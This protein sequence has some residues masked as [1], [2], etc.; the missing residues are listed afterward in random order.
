MKKTFLE[1]L[2]EVEYNLCIPDI[3][4]CKELLPLLDNFDGEFYWYHPNKKDKLRISCPRI[5][6]NLTM[7]HDSIYK[8]TII[9]APFGNPENGYSYEI[10]SFKRYFLP[11]PTAPLLRQ[12]L[13]KEF[14]FEG[15]KYQLSEHY[16]PNDN[17]TVFYKRNDGGLF[18]WNSAQSPASAY[19]KTISDLYKLG[20]IHPALPAPRG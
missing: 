14:E 2:K 15:A 17:Y 8:A 18:F 19:A 16:L 11:A 20:I 13:P 10:S 12:L 7:S 4:L 5:V 1:R 6:T 3:Y 9:G